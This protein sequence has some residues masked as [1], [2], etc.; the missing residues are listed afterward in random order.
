[1]A[2]FNFQFDEKRVDPRDIARAVLRMLVKEVNALRVNAGLPP[3]TAVQVRAKII[4][5]LRGL[6]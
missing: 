5:E 2:N 6:D 3:L 4:N 1:M